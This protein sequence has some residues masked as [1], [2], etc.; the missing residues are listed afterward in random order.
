METLRALLALSEEY[1]IMNSDHKGFVMQRFDVFFTG[2][3][4]IEVV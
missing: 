2:S 4:K 1:P 3:L